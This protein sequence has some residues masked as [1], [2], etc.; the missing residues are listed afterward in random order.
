MK[1]A[2]LPLF[3]VLLAASTLS[4]QP[5]VSLGPEA[6][7]AGPFSRPLRSTNP[8]NRPPAFAA[9]GRN[10]DYLVAW[11]EYGA[12]GAHASLVTAK[13]DASGALVPG[14]RHVAPSLR[15]FDQDAHFP[16]VA[17][18]GERFLV[19]WI[20]GN[21]SVLVGMR[22]ARDGQPLDPVPFMISMTARLSWVAATVANGEFVVTYG[23]T[24]FSSPGAALARITT[25]GTVRERDNRLRGATGGFWRDIESN[26]SSIFI[27][28][29]HSLYRPPCITGPFCSPAA[30]RVLVNVPAGMHE[31]TAV[32]LFDETISPAP[33]GTG[34]ATDGQRYLVVT[35]MRNSAPGQRGS[36][37]RGQ[38]TDPAGARFVRELVVS[39]DPELLLTDVQSAR[40][41]AVWTGGSYAIAHEV[42]GPVPSDNK[43]DIRLTFVS[44]IG[45]SL[46]DPVDVATSSEQERAPVL[47]PI[48]DSR[49]LVL[50]ERGT[51]ARPEIVARTAGVSF[52]HRAIR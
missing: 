50:Y 10:G 49:V 25:D 48:G 13:I 26:G 14:T 7:V 27:A 40:I 9:A 3:L 43:I 44:P 30:Q 52:K 5:R 8:E 23:A 16:A 17:F 46:V 45:M 19:V 6:V 31:T 29:D 47:L 51:P 21:A 38:L 20:E 24:G 34:L 12:S 4:A 32:P 11:S 18:D 42:F 41:D 15:P 33:I 36:L 39:T 35:W 2:V 28:H 22:F 1:Q 37:L